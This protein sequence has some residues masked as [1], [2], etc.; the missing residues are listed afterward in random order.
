MK[1]SKKKHEHDEIDVS[2]YINTNKETGLTDKE[3]LASR[4]KFGSNILEEVKNTSLISLFFR[5]LFEL[6]PLLLL[7][8]GFLSLGLSIYNNIA[9][10]DQPG[11][12]ITYVQAFVLISIVL[13]N[14]LFGSIQEHKSNNAISELKKMTTSQAKV[15]RNGKIIM[16]LSD[17]LVVGD[18]VLVEAGDSV[19]ADSIL[20][21]SINLKCIE[22]VLTGESS[23]ISKDANV[24]TKNNMPIGE[25]VN[26][27]FS[28]TDVI[29]GR[30]FSIVTA[31]G[32]KTEIGKIASL[33]SSKS[34]RMTPLQLK[35]KK[36]GLYLGIMGIAITF[37][38]FLFSLFVIEGVIQN[39][40]SAFQPS[41]LLGV[42]LAAA[43][44]PEGLSAIVNIILAIG[45]KRMSEKNGLIKKFA[46]VETF[47]STAVICS[48]KT[49]TLTMNKMTIVKLWSVE[50]DSENVG[51]DEFTHDQN[52]LLKMATLCTD[53]IVHE[54]EDKESRPAI[55]DPTEIAIVELA[56]KRGFSYEK[57]KIENKRLGNI[58]FDSDRKLMTVVNNIDGKKVVIVKGAP[59]VLF[60]KCKN[61]DSK[62]ATI[63][64]DNWSNK[65][66]R[67]LAIAIKEYDGK[68]QKLDNLNPESIEKDL[69]F[70]GLIGM[71]DPP[72]EEVRKSIEECISAGIKPVMITGDHLNTAI[73]IAKDLGIM[74]SNNELAITGVQLDEL[75]DQYLNDNIEKYSVFA[76]VSPVNKIRI[77]KA[78]QSRDQVVAMTGDGVNDAPAL[79]AA[80]I[81]C[82]MGITGTDVS[83]GAADMIL[84]DDNFSTI[85][86]SVKSGRSIYDNIRRI[87]KFL[88]STNIAGIVSIVVGMFV[89]YVAFE[90]MG[91]GKIM[92]SDFGN[93]IAPSQE[94][95]DYL[96]SNIRFQTTLTTI[97]ILLNHIVIESLPGV[98]LGTQR[99]TSS[100]MNK[101]PRSKFESILADRL[102]FQILF[103]GI[104]S[105]AM[106]I[107]GYGLGSYVAILVN[108]PGLRFY[109][110]SVAA[111]MTITIGGVLKSISMSSSISIF[112]TNFSEN[113]WVYIASIFSLMIILL[114]IMVPQLSSIFAER[115][116]FILDTSLISPEQLSDV[117][118]GNKKTDLAHWSIYLIGICGGIIPFFIL[119]LEKTIEKRFFKKEDDEIITSFKLIKKPTSK[120]SKK[121]LE[122]S[123]IIK[124]SYIRINNN[125]LMINDYLFGGKNNNNNN[126]LK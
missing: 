94:G 55:G 14:A 49:G 2:D 64:N 56:L 79:Q 75:S 60:K 17:E 70:I 100:L 108:A 90:V 37:V 24:I 120:H 30:G 41:L 102:L 86:E 47:G 81:G 36:L 107:I 57:W 54:G 82:A 46:A 105:G 121:T 25:Q 52:F 69:T 15:L 5:Q 112:K 116:D 126:N 40:I 63:I 68:S 35:L 84:T 106:T 50:S 1:I 3:V 77:V 95:L 44:I 71:I 26:R 114:S 21:S 23:E 85:V 31:V 119:E 83:K 13:I 12:L 38:T 97:Q 101:R 7:A 110:G 111:F 33:L 16:I 10:P 113:K 118:G 125:D 27:L 93:T 28:G 48:D 45:V 9:D 98:A 80:D 73:A 51:N 43:A 34:A 66:I 124:N 20:Y 11:I 59:D 99:T 87:V 53:S 117:F 58:P 4:E 19:S 32:N 72:R 8:A 91:W 67:V 104:I 39:G 78:W 122:N 109:Y 61:F 65:S 92:A 123:T 76:R 103:S 18:I 89:F 62:L 96:N 42:S 88:L 22:S 29:N 115:P 74:R 6:M